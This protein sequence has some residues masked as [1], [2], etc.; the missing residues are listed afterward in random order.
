L[1]NQVFNAVAMSDLCNET[2]A[3]HPDII[4][5]SLYDPGCGARARS[6]L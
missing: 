2:L 4:T 3:L 1:G 5:S 6:G